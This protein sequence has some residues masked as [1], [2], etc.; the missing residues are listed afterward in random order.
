MPQTH[1]AHDLRV[2][3]FISHFW[4]WRGSAW[5]FEETQAP[6]QLTELT[7]GASS[8]SLWYCEGGE[9]EHNLHA[10]LLLW[11]GNLVFPFVANKSL[12]V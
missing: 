5:L 11:K 7:P 3:H 1:H 12:S 10:H 4:S 2:W 6:N 8:P 9:A